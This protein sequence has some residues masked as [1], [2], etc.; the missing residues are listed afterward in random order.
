MMYNK[1]R[2]PIMKDSCGGKKKKPKLNQT[3]RSNYQFT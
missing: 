3:F 2:T 1:Y